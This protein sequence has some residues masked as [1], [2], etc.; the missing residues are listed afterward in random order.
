MRPNLKSL[1]YIP[2]H[3]IKEFFGQ[4]NKPFNIIPFEMPEA[5]YQSGNISLYEMV[6]ICL[7]CKNCDPNNI[8]EFGTFN[9][10]T[11]TNIAANTKEH[12]K[13]ITVDLPIDLK[14]KTKFPLEGINKTDENDELGYVGK[15]SKLYHKYKFRN[16][17]NQLW[18]DSADFPVNQYYKYFDFIFV[19][20]SH[21]YENT[22]NDSNN[23]FQCIK[24]KGFILWHDY[25]G[26]PGVTMALNE[27]YFEAVDAWNFTHIEGTSMVLYYANSY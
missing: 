12:T 20:A 27:L 19:D 23:V 3:S 9:G 22:L 5:T 15:T 26:W 4:I 21:T 25:Q 13:I 2:T 10:R 7:L 6:V 1:P 14:S 18:M 16:K 11:T 24:E 8:L 17:I